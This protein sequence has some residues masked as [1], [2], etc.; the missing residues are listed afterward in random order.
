MISLL[1]RVLNSLPDLFGNFICKVTACRYQ[2]PQKPSRRVLPE[3]ANRLP[4]NADWLSHL[5]EYQDLAR[6]GDG[7]NANM[8]VNSFLASAT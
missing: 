5:A 1:E 3:R 2:D 6:S 8:S 4:H 7:I